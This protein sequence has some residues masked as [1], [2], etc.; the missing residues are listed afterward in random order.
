MSGSEEKPRADVYARITDRIVAEL[1]KGVR[2]WMQPWRSGNGRGGVTRPL[3]LRFR[4]PAGERRAV[5]V[6]APRLTVEYR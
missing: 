2:P 1:E 4:L 5:T 3:R 6:G